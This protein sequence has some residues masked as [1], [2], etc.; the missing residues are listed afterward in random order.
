MGPE[1]LDIARTEARERVDRLG[2]PTGRQE[3]WRYTG[4]KSIT[5]QPFKPF[6]E[7]LPA[8]SAG[9]L[10]QLLI[11]GLDAH[12]AVLVNG[13]FVPHLSDLGGLPA[14]ARAG[15]LRG[16]LASDPE[17]LEGL[18]SRVAGE[19]AHV[20]SALNTAAMTTASYCCSG[21]VR[22][23]SAPLRLST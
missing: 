19:G 15:S 8:V 9:D 10:E 11:P 16:L 7:G 21:R 20:F 12:R 18:L 22:G 1:W 14:G 13:F 5:A 4:L 23:S 3:T 6:V 17:M 2:V